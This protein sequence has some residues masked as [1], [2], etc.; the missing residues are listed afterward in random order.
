MYIR[1]GY[2]FQFDLSAATHMVLMLHTH[3]ERVHLLQR[4]QRLHVEP[5]ARTAV[6]V[7]EFLDTF[8][9]RSARLTAPAGKLKIWYDNVIWDSGGK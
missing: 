3:P 7:D 1:I 2:E 6:R 8:N 4:P 5:E 9:N